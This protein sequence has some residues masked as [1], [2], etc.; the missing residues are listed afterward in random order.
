M[1]EEKVFHG[2]NVLVSP[3]GIICCQSAASLLGWILAAH[4]PAGAEYKKTSLC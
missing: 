4:S 3:T 1:A 2:T